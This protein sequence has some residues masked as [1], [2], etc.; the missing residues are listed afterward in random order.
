MLIF[1][2]Y[3]DDEE[4]DDLLLNL[5]SKMRGKSKVSKNRKKRSHSSEDE[6]P[7]KKVIKKKKEKLQKG[8]GKKKKVPKSNRDVLSKVDE[9]LEIE[10]KGHSKKFSEEK[11][12]R[13]VDEILFSDISTLVTMSSRDRESARNKFLDEVDDVLGLGK[14]KDEED[15]SDDD[16]EDSDSDVSDS[17]DEDLDEGEMRLL[18]LINANKIDVKV[19]F[20]SVY[21]DTD[22][23]F[24]R[25]METPEH[26]A[27]CPVYDTIMTG[28]EFEDIRSEEM[29]LVKTA[30][31]NIRAA[32]M[33]RAEALSV[34]SLGEISSTNMKLL[35]MNER[36][37]KKKTQS[38]LIDEILA[39]TT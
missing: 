15:T 28:S 9:I 35:T 1:V 29:S 27:E 36:V 16:S 39:T 25:Q 32:L 18:N 31:A 5:V 21:T 30:L 24:C 33:K 3:S 19:N 8:K 26:L 38:E 23:H 4:Q 10:E 14:V 17:E 22:C 13:K 7:V 2:V 6:E 12:M 37:E 20:P 11:V 34:T